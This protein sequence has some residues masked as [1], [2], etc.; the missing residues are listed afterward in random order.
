MQIKGWEELQQRWGHKIPVVWGE[1]TAHSD[2]TRY[3]DSGGVPVKHT[4][5]QYLN[6]ALTH[7]FAG[8][9]PWSW[10]GRDPKSHRPV[11]YDEKTKHAQTMK[12]AAGK[13][14]WGV[15]TFGGPDQATLKAWSR[16]NKQQINPGAP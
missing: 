10:G 2:E 3:Y 1:F 8:A 16:T 6:T 9:W 11:Q 5:E 12:D 4:L 14:K 7:K 15:D 13:D